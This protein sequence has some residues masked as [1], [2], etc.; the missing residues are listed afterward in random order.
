MAGSKGSANTANMTAA[1]QSSRSPK[2]QADDAIPLLLGRR[3]PRRL[4]TP[5]GA[6]PGHRWELL[7]NNVPRRDQQRLRGWLWR[8]LQPVGGSGS[9]SP[10][11]NPFL[12]CARAHASKRWTI[13]SECTRYG[14]LRKL[15]QFIRRLERVQRA[16]HLLKTNSS[17]ARYLIADSRPSQ[18]PAIGFKMRD[19][20]EPALGRPDVRHAADTLRKWAGSGSMMTA[21]CIGTFVSGDFARTWTL[22][23]G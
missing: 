5:R 1:A 3:L 11:E 20:L 16:V 4:R 12:R 7:R 18:S 17:T 21:A 6:G 15:N 19:A 10:K 8:G 9:A 2:R 13:G 14:K 22:R 23:C